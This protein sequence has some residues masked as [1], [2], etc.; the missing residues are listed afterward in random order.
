MTEITS[1]ITFDNDNGKITKCVL[2]IGGK[3][4]TVTLVN[5]GYN[6]EDGGTAP[7][8]TPG[9]AN[10]APAAKAAAPA[11]NAD[12]SSNPGSNSSTSNSTPAPTPSAP[13]QPS[14]EKE[15][16]TQEELITTLGSYGYTAPQ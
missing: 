9:S 4:F 8:S 16:N 10:A 13:L 11:A 14:Q 7:C 6:V 1:N 5:S 12:G 3:T 15:Y 2:Q